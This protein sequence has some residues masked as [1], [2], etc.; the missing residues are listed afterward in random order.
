MESGRGA[1]DPVDVLRALDR[2]LG[3]ARHVELP[4]AVRVHLDV[5]LL[6]GVVSQEVPG[7]GGIGLGQVSACSAPTDSESDT[8]SPG[9]GSPGESPGPVCLSK[10]LTLNLINVISNV[11]NT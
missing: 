11:I 1:A 5:Q 9:L 10:C 7:G 8:E 3:E 4:A 6:A 2:D